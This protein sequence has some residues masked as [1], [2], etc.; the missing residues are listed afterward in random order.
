MPP[1]R[2]WVSPPTRR[3]FTLLAFSLMVFV[4]SY[5]LETS[6]RMVGVSPSK[7][8][9]SYVG[10]LGT[11]SSMVAG[12]LRH[13]LTPVPP[14]GLLTKDPGYD[15]DGRRPQAW[16]DSLENVIAGDWAW[17]EGEIA[18]VERG[19]IGVAMGTGAGHRPI[20]NL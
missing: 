11:S 6:L 4:L 19:Q 13:E 8:S 17:E 18:G 15:R 9:T 7:L 20:Y 5:N 3:E 10:K 16:R 14:Q 2:S 1:P 12:T